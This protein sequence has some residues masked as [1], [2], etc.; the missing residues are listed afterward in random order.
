[1]AINN[2]ARNTKAQDV[3][4]LASAVVCFVLNSVKDA[5]IQKIIDQLTEDE[6]TNAMKYVYKGMA[7]GQNCNKLLQWHQSLTDKDGI[8][9][10]MRVL[11]DTRV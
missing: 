11:V 7:T 8:G 4:D 1:V 6:R 10:I 3:K 5:D 9:V 2:P